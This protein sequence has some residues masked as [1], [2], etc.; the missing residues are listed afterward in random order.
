MGKATIDSMGFIGGQGHTA[1]EY[2]SIG[3]IPARLYLLTRMF[4]VLGSQK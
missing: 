3:S 2:M 1:D 4:M